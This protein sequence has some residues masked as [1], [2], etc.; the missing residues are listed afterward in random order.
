MSWQTSSLLSFAMK[1]VKVSLACHALE[2][3]HLFHFALVSP[4][5]EIEGQ[6]K[7]RH[8]FV[9]A[10]QKLPNSTDISF[11]QW[12]SQ[13]RETEWVNATPENVVSYPASLPTPLAFPS[14][15]QR[16]SA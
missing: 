3:G 2:L 16:G 6:L 4:P 8:Q 11:A 5:D 12:L 1:E 14:E 15:D 7:W 10:A 9:S 13:M